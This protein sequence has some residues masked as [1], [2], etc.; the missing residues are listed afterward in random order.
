MIIMG[1]QMPGG[2]IDIWR[3][4]PLDEIFKDVLMKYAAYLN[5]VAVSYTIRFRQPKIETKEVERQIIKALGY[6]PKE[7]IV[8]CGFADVIFDSAYEIMMK[9]GGHL[10]VGVTRQ[11]IPKT[12][13]KAYQIK[14]WE[15]IGTSTI[16]RYY[17]LLDCVFVK[18]YF[19]VGRD[20]ALLDIFSIDEYTIKGI[21]LRDILDK[22][23]YS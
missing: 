14:Y 8:I 3:K 12:K 18:D 17:H 6:I 10:R 21:R 1:K 23:H 13:G 4:E 22:I 16:P 11:M 19:A 5:K 20:C 15:K 7:E 2:C 9:F